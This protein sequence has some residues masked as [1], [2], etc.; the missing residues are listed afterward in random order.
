MELRHLRYFVGVA[1]ALHFGRAAAQLRIAQPSLS[2]QIRQLE[3]ELQTTLLERT[4]RKVQ[5]TESGR[6]LLEHARDILAMA[7]RAAL[8]ARAASAG[9]ARLLRVGFS[10]W[11]DIGKLVEAVT[12]MGARQPGVRLQV[13][14]MSVPLQLVAL[15]DG[16]LDVGFVRPPLADSTLNTHL[17]GAEAFAVALPTRHPLAMTKRLR[18]SALADEPFVLFP[19]TTV[20]LFHDST[21]RI[22][23]D[24][25]FV[26]H[27]GTEAD[28]PELVLRLVAAGVGISLVP[29]SAAATRRRGV[30][31]CDLDP[32]P[33][34]LEIAL[35]WRKKPVPMLEE[36]LDVVC[37]VFRVR[38]PRRG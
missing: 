3:T 19:R 18:L 26:P 4:N 6:L 31:F 34:V 15:R 38:P 24:A 10:Y 25:G 17:L 32:S 29:G 27:V 28:T 37:G 20:P 9:Q 21:L 2:H 36:F 22:C 8:V 16:D 5:L 1:E 13:R 30:V 35:A 23:Q 12:Q 7:D 33:R 11:M 14:T